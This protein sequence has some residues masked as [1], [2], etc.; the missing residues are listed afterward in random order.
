MLGAMR[1]HR[2]TLLVALAAAVGLVA[3]APVLAAL[4]FPRVDAWAIVTSGLIADGMTEAEVDAILGPA[5]DVYYPEDYGGAVPKH[6]CV[7]TWDACNC[8]VVYFDAAGRVTGTGY[9]TERASRLDEIVWRIKQR[10]G[11]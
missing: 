4:A 5:L 10:F 7:K 9:S 8:V 6:Y 11:W 1:K 3:L 2:R